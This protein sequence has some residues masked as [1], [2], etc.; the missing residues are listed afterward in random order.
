MGGGPVGDGPLSGRRGAGAQVPGAGDAVRP[1]GEVTDELLDRRAAVAE[2]GAELR[3]LADLV[4][5]TESGADVLRD[6]ARRLRDLA[7]ALRE[8]IRGAAEPASVDDLMAG[9]RMFN[10]VI[11]TGNPIAPPMR[12]EIG[13]DGA[14]GWC[15]LGHAYEGPPMYGHGGVSAMLIDQLLGHAAAASGHPGVTTDLSVRYRR[16]VPL[17]VP[18]RIWGRVT[19]TEGRRVSAVGGI[20]TAAEPDV[21]LVEA[22]ARFARLRLD[23]ARRLFGHLASPEAANP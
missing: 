21:P 3:A 20:T 4:T 1:S 5:R 2:L 12:I 10:P 18:L 11:G 23:Q 8:R 7:P 17:D 16:P 19:G 9:V 13:E 22:E 14:E 6:C 15:T